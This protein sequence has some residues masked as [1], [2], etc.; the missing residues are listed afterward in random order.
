MLAVPSSCILSSLLQHGLFE[1]VEVPESVSLSL[2]ALMCPLSPS[3][4]LCGERFYSFTLLCTQERALSVLFSDQF[5]ISEDEFEGDGWSAIFAHLSR[6][7]VRSEAF[8]AAFSIR[9]NWK[10]DLFRN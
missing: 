1:L 6:G 2:S 4:S 9:N 3:L 8:E 10:A 5:F 7:T